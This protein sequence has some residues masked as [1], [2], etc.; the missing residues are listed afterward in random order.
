MFRL[1]RYF[2]L[3]SGLAVLVISVLLA[4]VQRWHEV[5]HL[6]EIVEEQNVALARSFANAVWPR[7]SS[8]AA[9][10][11]ELDGDALRAR[12]ETREIHETLKKL[13]TGLPVLK[14]KIYNPEGLTVYSSQPGQMGVVKTDSPGFI[15]VVR[16]GNPASKLTYRD[17]FSAFSGEVWNRDLV[18]T[19]VPIRPGNGPIEGVLELYTDVT[20]VL[21]LIRSGTIEMVAAIIMAF[22][23]LYAALFLIVRRADRALKRQHADLGSE[24]AERKR[25]EEEL[26]ESEARMRDLVECSSDWIWHMDADL[27]FSHFSDN[28]TEVTGIRPEEILG[29]TRLELGQ[30]DID[31]EKWRR[32]LADLE[33]RQPF[34]D[35][36]YKF[37]H[38][39]GR[40]LHFMVNGKPVFD[41]AGAFRG[42]RGVASDITAQVKAEEQARSAG[43]RLALAVD[44][45]SELFAL[46][47]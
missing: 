44:G 15:A 39:N 14:V 38:R 24:V 27:R 6:I 7:F 35:F 43:E 20:S 40:T 33:A 1:L 32:H 22:G 37:A 12:P 17:T 46:F 23:L 10:V 36:R 2:S 3:T 25:A 42:Y 31:D 30:G 45:L 18:E 19:Y 29:R 9:S 26:R 16:Q 41:E 4:V 11:S 5:N 47:D 8:Y 21:A 13:T 28:F 34:R